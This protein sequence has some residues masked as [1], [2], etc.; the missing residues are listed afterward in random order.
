MTY[1]NYTK[2]KFQSMSKFEWNKAT[3]LYLV[4]ERPWLLSMPQ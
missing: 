1:E 4:S 3:L 2:F